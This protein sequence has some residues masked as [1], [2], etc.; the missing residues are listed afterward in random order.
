MYASGATFNNCS[1]LNVTTLKNA[2]SI[3]SSTSFL[4]SSFNTLNIPSANTGYLFSIANPSLISGCS[5]VGGGGHA[6]R[7]TATGTFNFRGN[8]FTSYGASGLNTAAIY[9]DSS[10][11][12]TL[13]ILEGGSTPTFKNGTNATTS[14]VAGLKNLTFTNIVTGSEL[15]LYTAGTTGEVF[16]VEETTSTNPVYQYT[17]TGTVD[18]VVHNLRYQYYRV[19]G[20][21]LP[22]ADSSFQVTQI[23]DRN[24]DNPV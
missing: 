24:Y 22:T 8:T 4:N 7:V 15:R 2:I 1:F 6:F 10:G 20:Y 17:N 13:N 16:G 12:V 23:F 21:V 5:F 11:L 9:N 3:S 19:T 14:I 18:I